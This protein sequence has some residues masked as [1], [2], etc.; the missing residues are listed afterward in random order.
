MFVAQKYKNKRA[1]QTFPVVA[2]NTKERRMGKEREIVDMVSNNTRV[3]YE[4]KKMK[5]Y[6][7]IVTAE[8]TS[9]TIRK[10]TCI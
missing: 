4:I 5:F 8:T 2:N 6:D 10:E 7:K 1:K 3:V 9:R